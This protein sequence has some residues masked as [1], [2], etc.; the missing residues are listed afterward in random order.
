MWYAVIV[1]GV[2]QGAF[3]AHRMS[4]TSTRISVPNEMVGSADESSS[5]PVIT[6][7]DDATPVIPSGRPPIIT[8]PDDEP[9]SRP[10]RAGSTTK[11]FTLGQHKGV[12]EH[13]A[14]LQAGSRARAR[15]WPQG[16][17]FRAITVKDGPVFMIHPGKPVG[18]PDG[19][20]AYIE[21]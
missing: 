11:V 18:V 12:A 20:I 1:L 6:M 21:N 4:F 14:S 17:R 15:H 19:P 10:Q 7:L 2:A 13:A 5:G 9:I 8:E 16:Q 3:V